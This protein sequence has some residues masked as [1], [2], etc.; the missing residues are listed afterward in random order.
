M[1][2]RKRDED[3]YL[4]IVFGLVK[5]FGKYLAKR[6]KKIVDKVFKK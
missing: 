1:I 5:G 3:I 2:L 4:I 6:V